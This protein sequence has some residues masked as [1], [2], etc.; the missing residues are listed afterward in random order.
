MLI[1]IAI[2][3]YQLSTMMLYH[4]IWQVKPHQQRFS[5]FRYWNLILLLVVDQCKPFQAKPDSIKV[6]QTLHNSCYSTRTR[7]IMSKMWSRKELRQ[8]NTMA[9]D[10]WKVSTHLSIP[11]QPSS[12]W[13]R[14]TKRQKKRDNFRKEDYD[15]FDWL[16]FI[17]KSD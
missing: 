17:L 15:D 16:D 2:I 14:S 11:S 1:I 6:W 9:I 4:T 10:M 5:Q 3:C 12:E 7:S 8:P 13:T